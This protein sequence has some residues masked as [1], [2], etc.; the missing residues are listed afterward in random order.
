MTRAGMR[1]QG[2][3]RKGAAGARAGHA[4]ALA[5]ILVWGVTFVSTKVL[6]TS[7]NPIEILFLRFAIGFVALCAI[8]RHVTPFRGW[9]TEAL[10][11]AA[12]GTGVALYFLMENIAL[13]MTSS[14]NVGT[15]VAVSPLFVA[16]IATLLTREERPHAR[17][18]AGF[19]LAIGG[20][21]LIGSEGA[22]AGAVGLEGCVLA[23]L[24]AVAWAAYST[25]GKRLGG[26]GLSV[27]ATTKR[28]FLW[29]LAWMLPFLPLL[30]FGRGADGAG[31]AGALADPLM[32]AN[33]L[34]LGLVASAAC[35]VMWNRAGALIGV[36][37]TSAYLYLV[38]VVTV[39]ASVA[40]LGDPLTWRIVGG[41]ALTIVGLFLSEH[42]PSPKEG[43]A[44]G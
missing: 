16:L 6:L 31:L 1:E 29:G 34:F 20:I 17:F 36:V 15:I 2:D 42:A 5:T 7:M 44:K 23:L 22:Q 39:A 26:L 13:T 38:P 37:R 43:V 40:V 8:D 12:G 11:I 4:L 18:F 9:R 32:V 41:V 21:A 10:F 27:V 35:Y 3:V 24:A 25:I 14:S 28:T 19:A 30:G 33:L